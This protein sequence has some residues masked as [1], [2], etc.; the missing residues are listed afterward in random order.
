M[1]AREQGP[2]DPGAKV[3][4]MVASLTAPGRQGSASNGHKE[5]SKQISSLMAFLE[6]S[7]C[8]ISP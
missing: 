4:P 2:D 7:A 5:R 6:E 3:A 8:S 1:P